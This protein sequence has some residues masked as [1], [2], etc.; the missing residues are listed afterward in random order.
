MEYYSALKRKEILKYATTWKSLE[1]IML[2]D[3]TQ[4]QET[5]TVRFHLYEVLRT[6]KFIAKEIEWWLLRARERGMGNYCLIGVEFQFY[7]MKRVM[8]MD[9]G[10][11]YTTLWMYLISRNCTRKM[12]KVVYFMLCILYHSKKNCEKKKQP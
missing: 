1:D 6:V 2:S 10:N 5:N 12:A 4:S 9:V 7:K 3:I 8:R 11:G